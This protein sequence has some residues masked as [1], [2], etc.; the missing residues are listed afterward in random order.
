M[1]HHVHEQSV[2]RWVLFAAGALI[3]FSIAVAAVSAPHTRS[4]AAEGGAPVVSAIEVRF[5]DRKDGA[6]AVLDAAS[7]REV[8][9]VPP[10]SNGFIRGV[11]R[12]MVRG[13]KLESMG[14]GGAFRLARHRDG[15]L[16]IEDPQTHRLVDLGAFGPT[17]LAAFEALF[18]AGLQASR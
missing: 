1:S 15:S 12:G 13:R 17:N 9:V 10:N 11:L 7:G 5:E 2:P 14:R 16:T 3:A 8:S 6:V 18:T 4:V